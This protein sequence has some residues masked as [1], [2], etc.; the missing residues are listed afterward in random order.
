M[1]AGY[2]DDSRVEPAPERVAA[3][4]APH[5]GYIY[6]GPTA[7]Y[8][9]ARI[10]GK[11]PKRVILVGCSHRYP[12]RRASVYEKGAFE[13]PLATFPVDE[14]FASTLAQEL[15]SRSDD[16]HLLEHSLEVQLP[17]L[18]VSVGEVPIVPILFG[19]HAEAWHVDVGERL[20]AMVDSSDLVIASTDLSHYLSEEEA[21]RIDK[22]TIETVLTKD[23]ATLGD[24]LRRGTCSMCGGAAVKMAMGFASACGA[25]QWSLLD[26]RTSGAVSRDYDRVV[27]YGAISMEREP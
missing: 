21:N 19:A 17:F 11:K 1:V 16:P 22:H 24:G 27:G 20:A 10:R 5:A 3:I 7:G 9:Y 26:Y 2:M 6:S 15:D 4:V 8:V 12:I 13:T 25:T 18:H 23:T 14:A